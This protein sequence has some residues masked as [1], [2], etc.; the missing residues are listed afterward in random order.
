MPRALV[1]IDMQNALVPVVW[2]GDSLAERLGGL[3]DQAR[4]R[5]VPVIYL[6]QDGSPGTAHEPG[7]AGWELDSR[8]RCTPGDLV[9]RKSATDG[10]FRS[11]LDDHLRRLGVDT[12]VVTGI[13]T[14]FC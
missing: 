9:V 6:Q 2:N 12:L 11:G 14:D 10:F 5:G 8:V 7:T 1:V 13:G 4:A 3:A